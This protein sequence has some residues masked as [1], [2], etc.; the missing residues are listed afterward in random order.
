MAQPQRVSG[1]VFTKKLPARDSLTSR[2]QPGLMVHLTEVCSPQGGSATFD[3]THSNVHY[4]RNFTQLV[5]CREPKE[6]LGVG[7]GRDY[8]RSGPRRLTL[9]H[10]DIPEYAELPNS[11]H[12]Q[13]VAFRTHPSHRA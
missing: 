2:P 3:L 5:E 8:E 1:L 10:D 12:S 13:V 6:W 9:S 7:F 4:S 11:V